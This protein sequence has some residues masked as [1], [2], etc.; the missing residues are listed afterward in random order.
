MLDI[1]NQVDRALELMSEAEKMAA[2]PQR[3]RLN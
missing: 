2:G 3:G 1:D